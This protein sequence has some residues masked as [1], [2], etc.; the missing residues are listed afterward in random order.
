MQVIATNALGKDGDPSDDPDDST[1]DVTG[2]PEPKK[3]T[4]VRV[5]AGLSQGQTPA[6]ELT[7]SWNTVPGA[8]SYKVQ[9]KSE[10]EDY[11]TASQSPANPLLT[12]TSYTIPGT[13]TV[14]DCKHR[15]HGAGDRH[16]D[17]VRG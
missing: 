15:V 13:N 10:D 4:G 12:G 5:T 17:G 7:V 16:G 3:V 6:H 2:R 1:D 8:D 9:W 11:E 14:P